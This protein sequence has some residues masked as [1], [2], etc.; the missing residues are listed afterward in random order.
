MKKLI[1]IIGILS[2]I[3]LLSTI[4]GLLSTIAVIMTKQHTI[5]KKLSSTTIRCVTNIK[6]IENVLQIFKK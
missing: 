1:N 5:R 6:D 3:G 4:I 2:S